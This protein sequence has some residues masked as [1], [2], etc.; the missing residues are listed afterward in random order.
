MYISFVFFISVL[1]LIKKFEEC[2]QIVNMKFRIV[3]A[4]KVQEHS[5]QKTDDV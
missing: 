5:I 1:I 2:K 3:I 4:M